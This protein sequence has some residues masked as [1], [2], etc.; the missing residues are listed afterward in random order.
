[1]RTPG[2]RRRLVIFAVLSALAV[3]WTGAKYAR[4]TEYVVPSTYDVAVDLPDS[5]GIFDGAEVTYRGVPVGRVGPVR[6]TPTGVRAHL[7]IDK[8][9]RI[10]ADVEAHVHNRSAVGE[11]YVDLVPAGASGRDLVDGD[12]IPRSRASVPLGEE[13]LIKHLDDLATSVPL[14]DLRT[15]VTELGK[16]FGG[17]GPDLSRLID[18][19]DELV[20]NATAHLPATLSLLE[21]SRVVMRTQVGQASDLQAFA[22]GLAK[23][24]GDVQAGDAD[25]RHLIDVT[26]GA[27]KELTGLVRGLDRVMPALL[28]NLIVLGRIEASHLPHLEQFLVAFPWSVPG[29][30]SGARH[31]RA[32]FALQTTQDQPVCSQGY[33]PS[34]RWRSAHDDSYAAPDYGLQCT[35][36]GLLQ[37]GSG[38]APGPTR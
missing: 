21:S 32:M 19:S 11:Q 37:R 8:G 23:F 9:V 27:A 17:S 24:T 14:T 38:R 33:L 1:M 35:D 15:V 5:G 20:G 31:G 13:V 4:V 25:L 36:P 10:P 26:P 3:I 30:V 22:H 7:L 28:A 18:G 16:G 2:L 34:S 12:V 29:T 6:L